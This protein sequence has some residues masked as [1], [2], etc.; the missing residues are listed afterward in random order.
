M[1]F[2]DSVSEYAKDKKEAYNKAYERYSRY[3]TDDLLRKYKAAS[4]ATKMAIFTI[5]KERGV[6]AD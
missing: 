2:F 3:E 6:G 1:G 4:G 5:L